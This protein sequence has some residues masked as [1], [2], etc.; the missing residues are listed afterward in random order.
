VRHPAPG[1]RRADRDVDHAGQLGR[2]LYHQVV[3]G[4][5]GV[6]M[7]GVD[8]LLVA[9]AEHGGLLH[10]GDRQHRDV[11]ELGVVQPVEQVDRARP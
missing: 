4:H 8:L 5:V 9:G 3:L 11:V 10:P 7:V 1:Q 2:V 6:Q